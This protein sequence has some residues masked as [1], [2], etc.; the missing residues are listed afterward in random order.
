[1]TSGPQMTPEKLQH[2]GY[3][4]PSQPLRSMAGVGG[5][6]LSHYA[7]PGVAQGQTA[8]Y[9]GSYGGMPSQPAPS[10]GGTHPTPPPVSPMSPRGAT[11]RLG[12][13]PSSHGN[14]SKSSL[15]QLEQLVS[16][17]MSPGM[18]STPVS[19]G[20]VGA[21][22]YM[23]QNSSMA[24]GM[25]LSPRMPSNAMPNAS[26]FGNQS[27]SSAGSGP[28]QAGGPPGAFSQANNMGMINVNTSMANQNMNRSVGNQ[29]SP[30]MS[31]RTNVDPN[32]GV[33]IQQVQQQLQQLINMPQ[34]PHAQKQM[35]DL[36]E[37]LRNLRAQQQQQQIM[38]QRQQQ[39]M[40]Q[41]QKQQQQV[42][43]PQQQQQ[44]QPI[45]AQMPVQMNP[46]QMQQQQQQQQ[47]HTML[48]KQQQ[49]HLQQQQQ[50]QQ[51][52]TAPGVTGAPPPGPQMM[53]NV[54]LLSPNPQPTQQVMSP[55]MMQPDSLGPQP[56]PPT[57]H[58]QQS[59][60]QTLTMSPPQQ[61]PQ[62][63]TPSIGQPP[64]ILPPQMGEDLQP[65]SASS[66]GSEED[67]Q[68]RIK[69][70]Q[71]QEKANKIIQEAIAKAQAQGMDV[72]SVQPQQQL[73]VTIE[74][75]GE[76]DATDQTPEKPKKKRA[77]RKK[78][79]GAKKSE[80]KP[81]TPKTPKT[82]KEPK[83]PKTPKDSEKAAVEAT[84]GEA[85][86]E[87]KKE[88]KKTP[89]KAKSSTKKR[90][91]PPATF[92]AKK[93]KKRKSSEGSDV[94]ME[95]TPPPSPIIDD[96]QKRRSAR[97][98]KRKKYLDDLD[99]Q[100]SEEDETKEVDIEGHADGLGPAT[101]K[102]E[103]PA[104]EDAVIVEK[105]LGM[106]MGKRK[107]LKESAIDVED[108]PLGAPPKFETPEQTKTTENPSES[109]GTGE[110]KMETDQREDKENEE[111]ENGTEEGEK[112]E[113]KE[114]VH[115]TQDPPEPKEEDYEEVEVEEFYVKY[116]NFSYLHCE[117]RTADELKD[118]RI[119]S[120][121]KRYKMK[122]LQMNNY[123]V[124]FDEDDL[125]NP[126]YAEVDRVL[127]KSV[128][129]DPNTGEESTHYLVKWQSLPYEES[130]W[131]LE[132]DVDRNKIQ[133]YNKFNRP[134]TEEE[135]EH[136]ERP[137]PSDFEQYEESLEYNN[138]NRLR[139]YQLEGVNWLRFC[140]YNSQNC[141]LADEM[142]LGK[143]IQSITFLNDI[144]RYGIRGPFLVIAPLSTIANWQ[145]EF[146]T[147]TDINAITYHG[148]SPSRSMI[149]EYELYFR[150][151]NGQRIPDIF[152]FQVLITTY[153]I[154][155][156]DC[157]LLSQIEWRCA[158]IDEAHRLKNRNCKLLEG[159][160]MFE[161]EHRVLLTGTPLQN[162]VDELFSLLNFLEP[163]R[164]KSSEEFL[165]DFGDLKTES[166]VDKLKQL[167]KPMMLR[168]LK[169][170]VEKN[171]APKT[172]TI[173]EVE[174]TNIQKKY[175]RAILERNFTFLAKGS[176]TSNLPNLMNTMMELRK[177]CNHPYLI[178]GA[179]D[180]ILE[181]LNLQKGS[182]PEKLMEAMVQASGKLVLIDKLLP[183]LKA[184]GHKILI[185]SQM[186]RVLDI[187][188]DYL[189]N[190][191]HLYERL[192]GRI[193]GNLR[194]E[195]I[196][197][198][199]RPDSDRFVFL[200]C[201]RAG[202]LGINL[203]AA[204]TVIIFDS[205]W[206]P[207][208]DLQAQARC[209]RI[210]QTKDVKVYRLITR[211]SYEREMFDKASLKLGLDKAVLQSMGTKE[212]SAQA[213]M[214]KKELED[215]LKKGAYGAV[216]DDENAGDE[217]CEEDIDQILQRR[218]QVIQIE[219]EG[220]GSTFS[221]ASFNMSSNRTDIDIDDPN[222]WQKWAKKADIDADSL[223]NRNELIIEM[224]RQRKQTARYGDQNAMMENMSE[225]ESSSDD[226]DNGVSTGKPGK[227]KGR[228]GRRRNDEEFD[229]DEVEPGV[230][231]RAECFRVEKNL[232]V[233]G[234]GRWDEVLRHG[235][236]KRKLT[237]EDV[238]TISRAM[239]LYSLRHYHGD[240]R[241]KA[242]IWDLVTKS[243]D[244]D[245]A[246]KNHSGLSAPVPR[247]RKGRK[248]KKDHQDDLDMSGL[249]IDPD[250]VLRDDG[251]KKH[252]HRHS[253][254]V[255]LR[256]RLLYYLKHEVIGDQTES[257]LQG[258]PSYEVDIPA[259]AAD[260][261]PPVYWWDEEADRSLL[262]GV[263][264]H[265]YEK[266][267]LMRSDPALV[268]LSRCGPPDGK[269]LQA[270]QNDND[271][272]DNEDQDFRP[273]NLN[274]SGK[275][276]PDDLDEDLD[277]G[278]PASD[279]SKSKPQTPQ[280]LPQGDS[281]GLLP[282]PS[283]SDLNT[284]LRRVITGYQRS[285]KKEQQKRQ[286]KARKMEKKEKLEAILRERQMQKMEQQQSRW[287]RRE[288]A[289]FY[290]VVSTFGVEFDRK[291]GRFKW[292]TFRHIG[293]LEKKY[294]ETLTEYY[295]AFYHMCR[296]VCK[297]F[298]DDKEARPPNNVYVEPISEE[299]A[300]RC[301]A[302]I[303]LLNKIREEILWHPKLDERLKLC[304]G[305]ADMPDWWVCGTH[306]LDLLIGAAK[307]GLAR[308]DYHIVH[309]PKLCFR[310]I[311]LQ[312]EKLQQEKLAQAMQ[313]TMTRLKD[314]PASMGKAE[315]SQDSTEL[316]HST[317]QHPD[318]TKAPKL[319]TKEDIKE[320]EIVKASV[321]GDTKPDLKTETKTETEEESNDVEMKETETPSENDVK[322]EVK[323]EE[324]VKSET[325]MEVK[326]EISNDEVKEEVEEEKVKEE[327]KEVKEDE[328]EAKADDATTGVNGSQE[329]D[330]VQDKGEGREPTRDEEK[331]KKPPATPPP[332]SSAAVEKHE[333]D[334]PM[335]VL[336][337]VAQ[338]LNQNEDTNHST[339][340][341]GIDPSTDLI[342]RPFRGIGFSWPKDRVIFHRLENVCT[343]IEKGEW[344]AY[345]KM[346]EYYGD[347]PVGT[348][349]STPRPETPGSSRAGTPDPVYFGLQKVKRKRHGGI[350]GGGA[351]EFNVAIS[352]GDGL[353]LTIQRG[354]KSKRKQDLGDVA[355]LRELLGESE[356]EL[357][358]SSMSMHDSMAASESSLLNGSKN[359][360]FS[361]GEE[362]TNQSTLQEFGEVKK[363]RRGRKRK[364]DK[365]MEAAALA[366][367]G[368]S[369][370]IPVMPSFKRPALELDPEGRVPVVNIEDGSR[371]S[372][373]EA[374]KRKDL[375][376]WL[377]HHPGYMADD[378]EVEEPPEPVVF[379]RRRGRK[380]RVD[381][382]TLDLKKI[383]GDENV[384]VINR[385][386]GK[387][388][389]GAKAPPLKYLAE[390]LDQNAAFDVDPKWA[391]IVR[392]KVKLPEKLKSRVLTPSER[393]T[394]RSTGSPYS[395]IAM[396]DLG[397][398]SVST[399][400]ALSS[401]GGR[402]PGY[403]MNLA[404]GG[405]PGMG[406][407]NPLLG[408]SGFGLAGIPGVAV[409]TSSSTKT[410]DSKSDGKSEGG[411]GG[412]AS[413]PSSAASFPYLYN[414]LL[415]NPL[416]A[417]S[418][419]GFSLPPN[420]PTSFAALAQASIMN[421][422][423]GERESDEVVISD[424]EQVE[425]QDLSV[426]KSSSSAEKAERKERHKEKH[427]M[428]LKARE[429]AMAAMAGDDDLPQDLSMSKPKKSHSDKEKDRHQ[430]KSKL[431][432]PQKHS[433]PLK[434]TPEK[435]GEQEISPTQ[436]KESAPSKPSPKRG[437]FLEKAIAKLK[438]ATEGET[439]T[440]EDGEKEEKSSNVEDVENK[441]QGEEVS[442]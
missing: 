432:S 359:L 253:N 88:K 111:N 315:D 19:S 34:N 211:N 344:P 221:K 385:E 226:D 255:L 199:S 92:I 441:E 107:Y 250:T 48:Q 190:R 311:M 274:R 7:G 126:D 415:Y 295:L 152:K 257:I 268:F 334:R 150:D 33:K 317:E 158:V 272:F 333:E 22:Q 291:A 304:A 125:F 332:S 35:L 80:K 277:P 195:A 214:T 169:E 89:V 386:T 279:M 228:R 93:K 84:E 153:E 85:K 112:E 238:L 442:T 174:L 109:Q 12:H 390:W 28:N 325:A 275:D 346:T 284:R 260:G 350:G 132:Q 16:P 403:P 140:W 160:K 175:Y 400:N 231:T 373:D 425:A 431:G 217:F 384:S 179:E 407:T 128:V 377:R 159:L 309:D 370:P 287:S 348:P 73:P 422:L 245:M 166:Q 378:D 203:T 194:Q 240:E 76:E 139:E 71:S 41:Q 436:L 296:R 40:A 20:A 366:A 209:H 393:R 23:Q 327:V 282:F 349:S 117:W 265:G 276:D 192:D 188:E 121:I 32:L 224:P 413:S 10:P 281:A 184:G 54:R 3:Q 205:D 233:Y 220:K 172:E 183:K 27:L 208:N 138:N 354:R 95:V 343:C 273:A 11:D 176:G 347:T 318:T 388:I 262:I 362:D 310:D 62:T 433:T 252:L 87:E 256:V 210:G 232:L 371:L 167:L 428:K 74:G 129:T 123:F 37:Q 229:D 98:T 374:P 65:P 21:Q 122:R 355:R 191:H 69:I 337:P 244:G 60:A 247:G 91:M 396:S 301:L 416:F 216:M 292:D 314:K 225:L 369:T 46:V 324:T 180:T 66:T 411:K 49:M 405:L 124:E 154:I 375:E 427:R 358:E 352:E 189:I 412:G 215:L 53:P 440:K 297:K 178:N 148:T 237:T 200:L 389:T 52:K 312:Y 372:G 341:E 47:K 182:P 429:E 401:L 58:N 50:Q 307:H 417:Q 302:R 72:P 170:D 426:K 177:C 357:S 119:H 380:P 321:D 336:T 313:G 243:S 24:P 219:S 96:F 394:K 340:L 8:Q 165:K 382:A 196:D 197:R 290:R 254:K 320:E 271:D 399:M 306:D 156:S 395:S 149:Q 30:Q 45:Q 351:K 164:F 251:Y 267:N 115:A 360:E 223:A 135:K 101:M 414:P 345:R 239:L 376:K 86:P 391:H 409:T 397:Y 116:K 146:E 280:E 157:E 230:Y 241:I 410:S 6:R 56:L 364:I 2:F 418:L 421:G 408:Y 235:R 438:K 213:Q 259:P 114:V 387:K 363:K 435:D 137:T 201:T 198:F 4:Q 404:F 308:T 242:F 234:W 437:S 353:K 288:E 103:N 283:H 236:F 258:T 39:H 249:D 31:P 102:T 367:A 406:L 298:K 120:K 323:S 423:R 187:L 26:S 36:Q 185:F 68:K 161:L 77:P 5:S 99:L 383:T 246:F 55:R 365:L 330:V 168:R 439:N 134:L 218:T 212:M 105:I 293:K 303:D 204:D 38:L 263:F 110:E 162:N 419:G 57:S 51:Q 331:E 227:K 222:F 278:T 1:M 67:Q 339:D 338:L 59:M 202:G 79:E 356:G 264:K 43:L 424:E 368:A 155:I 100:L 392:E 248:A 206:N 186:I 266:Y 97:N 142:G 106:R 113:R 329:G 17:G 127:C 94:D 130:T 64:T 171:L 402:I 299:R 14:F 261:E 193:R 163:K 18:G 173:I 379:E 207:Q 29:M 269:L 70:K 342:F 300:S 25:Q 151:E 420:I 104:E 316:G 381:P 81:K 270:E 434:T 78:G 13:P 15:Q 9:Q 133:M 143:T 136:K 328:V 361:L 144:V 430:E 294:D 326:E 398:P 63:Q 305:S 44:Q 289:D 108:V 147:W 82:P 61:Q 118:K 42:M 181:E 285:H 90:K 145:R 322:S 141:I 75:V 335:P 83:E 131:E 286:Q 319:E